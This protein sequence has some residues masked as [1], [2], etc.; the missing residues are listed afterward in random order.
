MRK[1]IINKTKIREPN[2]KD[3]YHICGAGKVPSDV[4]WLSLIVILGILIAMMMGTTSALL[5]YGKQGQPFEIRVLGNCSEVNLTE[6]TNSQ[7]KE[8][9]IINQEMTLMGG[10]TWNYTFVNT[11]SIGTYTFSWNNPCIDCSTS[12]DCGNSFEIGEDINQIPVY[13]IALLFLVIFAIVLGYFAHRMDGNDRT[14]DTGSILQVNML[15]HIKPVLWVGVWIITLVILFILSNIG[16]AFLPNAMIGNL[17]FK[18]YQI[19]FWITIIGVPIYF[20]YLIV[21]AVESK[22][23]QKMI[24]RGVDVK[25]F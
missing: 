7:T 11:T 5:G 18:F 16:L 23:L 2:L 21:K 25:S 12:G 15:K 24:E 17:F 14:D 6:V 9:Y 3:V 10:Q 19:L 4:K 13:Y 22:E 8:V 20:I 1:E